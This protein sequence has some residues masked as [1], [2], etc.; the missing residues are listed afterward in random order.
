MGLGPL[1][2]NL[3]MTQQR[4][5]TLHLIPASTRRQ[6]MDWSLALISQGIE[7]V[8]ERTEAGWGLQIEARDLERALETIG[9]YRRENR[10]MAWHRQLAWPPFSFH[11]GAVWWCV[12]LV[13][14][15][16]L[17][18]SPGL[19]LQ[20]SGRMD[21]IAVS[22]GAWW[23][24]FTSTAL[25]A[26]VAHLAANL[27]IGFCLVGLAM[28][29]F[30]PG[31]ALLAISLAGAGGNLVGFLVH[32]RPYQ[33]VGASGMVMGA[34][35][36]LGTQL[37]AVRRFNSIG[38][39]YAVTGVLATLMLFVLIGLN[40]SSDVAAHLGGLISGFLIGILL[41]AVPYSRL[42]SQRLNVAAVLALGALVTLTWVL[43]LR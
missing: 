11:F 15:A 3:K 7:S 17:A 2:T 21:S 16:W 33:G 43:A 42:H 14:F 32:S 22:N 6:A 41:A 34:L 24:L 29:R 27:A 1:S 13:V 20:V 36:L 26:D 19:S 10:G 38:A 18:W 9:L 4:D 12:A 37:F 30:G 39:R 25:H 31:I 23:R 28:G 35:G 5:E 40:P 8:V